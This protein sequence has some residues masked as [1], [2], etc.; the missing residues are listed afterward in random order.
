MIAIKQPIEGLLAQGGG[1]LVVTIETDQGIGADSVEIGG[2][3]TRPTDDL[4]QGLEGLVQ[5]GLAGQGTQGDG[6]HITLRLDTQLGANR[7]QALSDGIGVPVASTLVEEIRGQGRQA[8]A[9][10]IPGTARREDDA[11]VQHRQVGS[12]HEEHFRTL[13]GLPGVDGG[14]SEQRSTQGQEAYKE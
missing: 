14:R 11:Q 8:R 13:R 1:V 6:G 9:V 12:R 3:E 2:R 7:L 10:T 4:D 5:G